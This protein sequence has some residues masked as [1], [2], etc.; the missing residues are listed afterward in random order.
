MIPISQEFG[1][2]E[3]QVGLILSSFFLSYAIMQPIGG[4]LADKFGSRK[5]ILVSVVVWPLFTILTGTAW[6]FLSLIV[7]RFLFGI[8]EGSY[9]SASSVAVA[10]S[11]SQHERARAK[12]ILT[13]ATTIGSVLATLVAASLS[14]HFGWQ[15][16]FVILGVLGL[17]LALLYANASYWEHS[18]LETN[19][20]TRTT[21]LADATEDLQA[22]GTGSARS[23][24]PLRLQPIGR[25]PLSLAQLRSSFVSSP[26][27]FS[28]AKKASGDDSCPSSPLCFL[29]RAGTALPC[30]S[31]S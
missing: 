5:V 9:P 30:T 27:S 13:S 20:C 19:I 12:S 14:Q 16:M 22:L 4:S 21:L 23:L 8:G 3:T 6:S 26:C 15:I 29:V 18:D 10:E 17:F 31:T 2:T 25:F 11:F 1:L 28:I 24:R 7:I